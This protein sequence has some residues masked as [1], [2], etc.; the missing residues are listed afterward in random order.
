MITPKTFSKITTILTYRNPSHRLSWDFRF[1]NQGTLLE[2]NHG[3]F[4]NLPADILSYSC[5][6][7]EWG[8]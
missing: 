1:L 7:S 6:V 5:K 2:K 8:I 4:P 3:I